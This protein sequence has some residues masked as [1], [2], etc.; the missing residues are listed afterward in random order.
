[1]SSRVNNTG[2]AAVK[3]RTPEEVER[4]LAYSID[5]LEAL[6]GE[7]DALPA[8]VEAATT[9]LDFTRLEELAGWGC[10]LNKQI[11]EAQ[12]RFCQFQVERARL[13]CPR[14]KRRPRRQRPCMRRRTPNTSGRTR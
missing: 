9:Q 2:Q 1:M 13:C 10:E 11:D 6:R 7:R 12:A 8:L 4:D 3:G 5:E 14:P